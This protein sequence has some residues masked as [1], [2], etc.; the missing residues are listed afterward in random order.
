ML[1]LDFKNIHIIPPAGLI[2]QHLFKR[3]LQ[4]VFIQHAVKLYWLCNTSHGLPWI[5]LLWQGRAGALLS[6]VLS[7]DKLDSGV[8]LMSRD[9]GAGTAALA[10][11]IQHPGKR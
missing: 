1:K 6:G 3:V 5:T 2:R 4:S 10:T 9:M 8:Q 11:I 7:M